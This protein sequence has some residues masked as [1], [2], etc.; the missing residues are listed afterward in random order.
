[1]T[2]ISNSNTTPPA[3]GRD[4]RRYPGIGDLQQAG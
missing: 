4:S 2:I 3:P 1:M